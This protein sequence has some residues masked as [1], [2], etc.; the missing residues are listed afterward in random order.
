MS[1][2]GVI[3]AEPDRKCEL[4][5]KVEETR[6]YGPGGKRIC[7]ECGMKDPAGTEKRMK[8]YLFGEREGPTRDVPQL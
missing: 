2:P 1:M 6:P 3:C 7:Y 8:A 4:C 5:G